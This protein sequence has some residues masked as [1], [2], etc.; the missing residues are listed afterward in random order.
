MENPYIKDPFYFS[1]TTNTSFQQTTLSTI[2]RVNNLSAAT[3]GGISIV[4]LVYLVWKTTQ[5]HHRFY[6]RLLLVTAIADTYF[7]LCYAYCQARYRI[8]SGVYL[9]SFTGPSVSVGY[10]GQCVS[11]VLQ[12]TAPLATCINLA[13][14]FFF[15]FFIVKF[16]KSP[17]T[18][19]VIAL[20]ILLLILVA[21]IGLNIWLAFCSGDNGIDY[22]RFWYEEVP[23][24][25]VLV[26]DTNKNI[27]AFVLI[28]F[29]RGIM[30]SCSAIQ[31][32]FAILTFRE[33]R[34][35]SLSRSKKLQEMSRQFGWTLFVQSLTTL[36]P[37]VLPLCVVSVLS[38]AKINF[39]YIS[40][41]VIEMVT[42]TPAIN[43]I[44]TLML[45]QSYRQ[46]LWNWIRGKETSK[47]TVVI[48]WNTKAKNTPL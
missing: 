26:A 22:A 21:T 10:S 24:P 1:N 42:W 41:I 45:I 40:Q 13:L 31:I 47:T 4:L 43:T 29:I 11:V 33:L 25:L 17:S 27:Y 9:Y 46:R 48:A 15:R 2:L 34:R 5:H 23:I 32:L 44:A 7:L 19:L 37:L 8:N 20:Y 38:L 28:P 36:I 18:C 16:K 35:Q 3:V 6:G 30:F 39:Q 14:L 12:V